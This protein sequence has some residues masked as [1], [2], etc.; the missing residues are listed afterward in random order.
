M[1]P[2]GS[3]HWIRVMK[4]MRRFCCVS[5]VGSATKPSL[6]V[7]PAYISISCPRS[8]GSKL[9]QNDHC[10]KAC[11]FWGQWEGDL[12]ERFNVGFLQK[13]EKLVKLNCFWG[14][15]RLWRN[16]QNLIINC[17]KILC[18]FAK[19]TMA[20]CFV[21]KLPENVL[22]IWKWLKSH[23]KCLHRLN[24]L[25]FHNDLFKKNYT[26]NSYGLTFAEVAEK[27]QQNT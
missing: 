7:S 21:I 19:R 12:A 20:G 22:I 11:G 17:Q 18:N 27:C 8:L 23:K 2:V 14:I 10:H 5:T 15:F 9:Y 3:S 26:A 13:K 4:F 25:L 6:Q 24:G 16:K 1:D